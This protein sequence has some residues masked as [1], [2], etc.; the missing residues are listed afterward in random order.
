M[1]STSTFAFA[2]SWA[3]S[4]KSPVAPIAALTRSRPCSSLAAPGYFNFFWMSLTV[5]RPFRLYL[6]STTSSFSTRCSCR[7]SSACSSVVP[8]GTVIRFFLVIT[9]SIGISN[10]V[11]KRRSRL[12]RMPTR[13][14]FGSVIGTP[15]ILYFF[16]TSSASETLASGDMVTGSTIMPLSDRFTLSTSLA[17]CSMVR[18]R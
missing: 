18:L 7:I 13:V 17:C 6:S 14:P 15:E 11:S 9:L 5:I 16:M 4:R 1:A 2:S 8:T 12:V 10:R 3:R